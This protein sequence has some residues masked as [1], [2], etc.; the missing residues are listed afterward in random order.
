MAVIEEFR[1]NGGAVDEAAGGFFKGKP[2]LILHHEGAKTG[3]RRMNPLVYADHD[4]TYV[5]AA[6]RGGAPTHPDWL[7]NVRAN[8]NVTVELGT[9]TFPATA[10][11]VAD[12]PRRD[13]LYA[14]L[15]AIMGQFADYE[16][17]TD[18]TIPVVVLERT[19]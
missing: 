5:V 8:P 10:T 14:K 4:G 18:R 9:E 17:K 2:L 16:T 12:G 7:F 3:K 19:G 1:A 6:S 13:E 15:I 11:V